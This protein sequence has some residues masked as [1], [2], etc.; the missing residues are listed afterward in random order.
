MV[1]V[2][3]QVLFAAVFLASVCF[4]PWFFDDI[5]FDDIIRR[6]SFHNTTKSIVAEFY[7]QALF[8]QGSNIISRGS[9]TISLKKSV[10]SKKPAGIY[11]V[12]WP[13][14]PEHPFTFTTKELLE[15][16]HIELLSK[17]ELEKRGVC[18]VTIPTLDK[19][20]LRELLTTCVT[21]CGESVP[22]ATS[23][24]EDITKKKKLFDPYTREDCYALMAYVEKVLR[25]IVVEKIKSVF[26]ADS[27]SEFEFCT[28]KMI[29]VFPY[30]RETSSTDFQKA[31]GKFHTDYTDFLS[32]RNLLF[33]DEQKQLAKLNFDCEHFVVVNIWI[34]LEGGKMPLLFVNPGTSIISLASQFRGLPDTTNQTIAF[35]D[36]NNE[37]TTKDGNLPPFFTSRNMKPLD[38]LIFVSNNSNQQCDLQRARAHAGA[39]YFELEDGKAKWRTTF[40]TRWLIQTKRK[41]SNCCVSEG[42]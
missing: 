40:E 24:R 22:S 5:I 35:P 13:D 10:V 30:Y 26:N 11:R 37:Y 20:R 18:Q 16:K 15:D 3:S 42:K 9:R 4:S 19:S 17:E 23:I 1:G 33:F 41:N 14:D 34:F 21:C 12:E 25:P 2:S 7:C 27:E 36:L 39:T 31:F 28:D 29:P 6:G 38:A 32:I 8:L